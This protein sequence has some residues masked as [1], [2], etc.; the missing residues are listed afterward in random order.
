MTTADRRA[1]LLIIPIP[2]VA[3]RLAAPAALAPEQCRSLLGY[4]A[5]IADPRHRRG[6]RH[7]LGAVLAVAV[8][9]VLADAKSLAA[10]GEWANDAPSQVLAA[11]G[12]HRDPLS[13][14]WRPP[15][16]ATARSVRYWLD[17]HASSAAGTPAALRMCL[18]CWSSRCPANAGRPPCR[19]P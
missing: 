14:A 1:C 13:G 6:R 15:G 5:Q 19:D 7:A 10:I 4:L 2:A 9:A 8:A 11:M 12:V 18:I 3:Q 17:S 16:E